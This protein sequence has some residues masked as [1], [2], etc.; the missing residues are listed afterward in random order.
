MGSLQDRSAQFF[1]GL[2]EDIGD[3]ARVI[4]KPS[5]L[6]NKLSEFSQ[7]RKDAKQEAKL[8]AQIRQHF[9]KACNLSN[10]QELSVSAHKII[11]EYKSRNGVKGLW[12]KPYEVFSHLNLPTKILTGLGLF[13]GAS[14]ALAPALGAWSL[15]LPLTVF[16]G[17]R[18]GLARRDGLNA[19]QEAELSEKGIVTPFRV[20]VKEGETFY[21]NVNVSEN[22]RT[23]FPIM[24]APKPKWVSA[25]Y[26]KDS[27]K[28]SKQE[29][30]HAFEHEL[31]LKANDRE[32]IEQIKTVFPEN[33]MAQN[34]AMLLSVLLSET[35]LEIIIETVQSYDSKLVSVD[36]ELIND[37]PK[38]KF[39]FV[40]MIQDKMAGVE[41]PF[42]HVLVNALE[43]FAMRKPDDKG[44]S[45]LNSAVNI[46]DIEF[47]GHML[48][49]GIKVQ[50]EQAKHIQDFQQ[51]AKYNAIGLS[52]ALELSLASLKFR[53][54]FS[55][56]WDEREVREKLDY[57]SVKDVVKNIDSW[58]SVAL[59]LCTHDYTKTLQADEIMELARPENKHWAQAYHEIKTSAS[60]IP[61]GMNHIELKAL[62]QQ[63]GNATLN[64]LQTGKVRPPELVST[65]T[66]SVKL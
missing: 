26:L 47:L 28:F 4:I 61:D 66:L 43:P 9:I 60:Q 38:Q 33:E 12:L 13:K 32:V 5:K 42:S 10:E 29:A 14:Y 1:T 37:K 17:S 31:L 6:K 3:V 41:V 30:I 35:D 44:L 34:C 24:H 65:E 56:I 16:L 22:F 23:A 52:G 59:K 25:I 51:K 57:A 27:R 15:A 7:R 63:Y 46:E 21:N 54:M 8:N 49:R 50:T 19:N 20:H 55:D 62:T 48:V 40:G 11:E 45:S 58:G 36:H 39:N 64:M 2:W 53:E 18:V